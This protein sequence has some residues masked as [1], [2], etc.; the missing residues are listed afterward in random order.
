ME[1]TKTSPIVLK[2]I[3]TTLAV[4][5]NMATVEVTVI[6]MVE[7]VGVGVGVEKTW[8]PSSSR[9]RA[10]KKRDMRRPS[11]QTESDGNLIV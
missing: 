7:G 6:V 8:K 3:T 4:A 11:I 2:V 10:A 5:E 1:L 9:A